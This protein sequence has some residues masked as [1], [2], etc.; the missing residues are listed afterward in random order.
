VAATGRRRVA[1]AAALAILG[2]AAGLWLAARDPR[3][4]LATSTPPGRAPPVD[5][6]DIVAGGPPPDGIPPLDRLRFHFVG[7]VDWLAAAEPVAVVE[8]GGQAKADPLQILVWHEIVNDTVAGVPVAV[9]YCPLCNTAVSFRRPVVNGTATTFGTSGKLYRSNLVMYDRATGSLWP[10]ALGIAVI[11]ELTGQRLERVATQLVAWADF[12]AGFPDSQVLSRDTGQ[13]R[14][15]GQ[16]PYP[17][18]DR[19]GGQP[20]LFDGRP[21]GRLPAVERVL[22]LSEGQ[23]HL[24]VPYTRLAA[25]ADRGV[26]AVN[27]ELA[28][29]PVLV[30]WRS[31]ATSALDRRSIAASRNVGAAAVFSRRV[32]GRV[33]SF[34]TAA[35]KVAD[36]QAASTWDPFGRAVAGPLTGTRLAP[37][38]AMDSFWFDWAAFH[39]DTTIWTG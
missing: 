3:P 29:E 38:T 6:G 31:G 33:L 21:D 9:T 18:Y 23:Q 25:Q 19:D 32:G 10:Q 28:G 14:P 12:R 26:A 30:V 20:L 36:T 8:L 16:N 5:P 34:H 39:P 37:A 1:S 24:A 15:Y 17:L 7:E 13:R 22:G 11:G 2:V 27:L 4:E 35:G